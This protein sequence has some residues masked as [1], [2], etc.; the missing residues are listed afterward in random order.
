MY[1]NGLSCLSDI[2]SYPM[3]VPLEDNLD[4][5]YAMPFDTG[6]TRQLA[7]KFIK[8]VFIDTEGFFNNV[9]ATCD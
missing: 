5:V 9:T 2:F 3:D 8:P 1:D 4:R 7:G 6:F